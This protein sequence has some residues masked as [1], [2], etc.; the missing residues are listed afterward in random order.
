MDF[1]QPKVRLIDKGPNKGQYEI[2]PDFTVGRSKDLM[3]RG[4]AFYA[5][6]DE[7]RGLWSTDEYDVQ[8]LVDQELHAEAT[9]LEKETGNHYIVKDLRSFNTNAWA[10]FRKFLQNISDNSHPLDDKLVFANTDVKK[11]DH[12]S[13]RLPYSLA[14][15][16][17]SAWD[18]LI[19]TLYSVEERA[20]IE[21]TIGAIVSGDSKKIQKFLVLYGPA[22]TGK[23]TILN[24]I[25]NLFAGYT[26]TFEA[27]ALGSSN[28]G[29]ATEAFRNNPLIAI[30]H[31]GDLSNIQ[32]NTKLNSIISHEEMT[33]NEKYKPSYTSRVNAFL[34]MGT[35][36]P[37]KISDAKSGIIRRLI[38]VHPTGVKIPPGHYATLMSKISFE[39][40]AIAYHCL[41]V[42]R[43]MGKNY[44]NAYRPLEMMLQTDVFFNFIEAN[45]DIFKSQDNTSLKQA[46]GLY[47][48]YCNE[49]GVERLLPQYKVREELRNYFEHFHDRGVVNGAAVRSYYSGF[50]ANKFKA[51]T[52]EVATFSLVLDETESIFDKE[53]ADQPAQEAKADGTPHKRWHSVRTVLSQ[54]DTTLVHYVKVPENHIVIDFDLRGD[55]GEKS[56]ERN[57]EAASAWPATYAELS[58]GGGGVHLHYI[59]DGDT[60]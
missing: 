3:V 56:L 40:G 8:R 33:M 46:Y 39:L 55:D 50:T 26:T 10:Q 53:F 57:L 59:Y 12:A 58:K 47:K 35:N 34:L 32:D 48:E 60:D 2:Y 19:G 27:K 24:I 5:I 54:I 7:A 31:D 45:Y 49:T 18:E 21:W 11:S 4:R 30:Q 44:Y 15:G 52:K 36:Q 29:F 28:N 38:D 16:D 42:Y 51:P 37:V 20:K 14:E 43:S 13:K 6:W 17:Y 25:E 23:S 22:G 1:Y 9:R 41:E